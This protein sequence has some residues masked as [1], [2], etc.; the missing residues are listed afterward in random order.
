VDFVPAHLAI[1][2][3]IGRRQITVIMVVRLLFHFRKTA[4]EPGSLRL[5][6]AGV[7]FGEPLLFTLV[8]MRC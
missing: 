8:A 2:V 6:V 3:V 5:A 1:T 7:S 4:P